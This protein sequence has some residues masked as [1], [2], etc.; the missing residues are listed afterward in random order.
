MHGHRHHDFVS[1]WNDAPAPGGDDATRFQRRALA[2]WPGLDH[3]RLRRTHGDPTRIARL[4][5]TR[6]SLPLETILFLLS[7]DLRYH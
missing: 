2:I 7:D 3:G 1:D 6:T 4:V 5:A